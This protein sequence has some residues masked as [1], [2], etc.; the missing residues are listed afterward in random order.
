MVKGAGQ[1]FVAGPPVVE[2]GVGEKVSKEQLGGYEIH[3]RGSGAVDNEV[4]S[5]DEAF[6]AIRGFL[7]YMP[8]SVWQ[9]PPRAESLDDP[10][11]RG[12]EL[13]SAI[14]RDRRR[15]YDVRG[16]L[17]PVFDTGSFFE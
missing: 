12:E 14:P 10:K 7:S 3:A 16:T 1:L 6:A 15:S 9:P 5:E 13:I 8:S 17:E 4:D 2:R 11:R